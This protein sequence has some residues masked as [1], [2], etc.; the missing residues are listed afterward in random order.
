[1]KKTRR[2]LRWLKATSWFFLFAPIVAVAIYNFKDY[3]SPEKG[4][5]FKQ[6]IEVGMGTILAAGAGVLLALGKTNV[7]KGI[8]GVGIALLLSI[9]LKA[10]IAD[11]VLILSAIFVGSA[12]FEMLQAPIKNIEETYK[13]EKQAGIQAK[14]MENVVKEIR[15]PIEQPKI[16]KGRGRV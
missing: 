15:Q 12:I 13:Y 9:L 4:F 3:Y 8:R 14:A 10:I 16:I 7:F 5:V 2:K 1:M 6:S 11:L